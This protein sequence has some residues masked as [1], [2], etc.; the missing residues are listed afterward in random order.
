MLI[1]GVFSA[2]IGITSP[3]RGKLTLG[4]STMTGNTIRD[5]IA[6]IPLIELIPCSVEFGAFLKVIQ[7]SAILHFSNNLFQRF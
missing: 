3:L 6:E 2:G 1:T 4:K 7:K 5:L